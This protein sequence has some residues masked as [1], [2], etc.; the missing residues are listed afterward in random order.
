MTYRAAVRISSDPMTAA[1][2]FEPTT[3]DSESSS[4]STIH[5]KS[6]TLGGEQPKKIWVNLALA[7]ILTLT[8]VNILGPMD[9]YGRRRGIASATIYDWLELEEDMDGGL[10]FPGGLIIPKPERKILFQK[11]LRLE[12]LEKRK[13]Y[14]N[15]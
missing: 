7:S 5:I 3:I 4:G 11:V 2:N 8:P 1:G 12:G 13:P 9:I 10:L 6:E 15:F 14:L